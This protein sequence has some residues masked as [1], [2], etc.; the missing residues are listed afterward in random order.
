MVSA[1]LTDRQAEILA[2]IDQIIDRCGYPPTIREI[3][4]QFG[5][6]SPNAVR[7]HLNALERKGAIIRD[8]TLARGLR[9]PGRMPRKVSVK[10]P[11][12]GKVS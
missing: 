4:R 12:L 7:I 5:F 9:I 10:M 11:F 6:K 3:G 1:A 8:K 2:F